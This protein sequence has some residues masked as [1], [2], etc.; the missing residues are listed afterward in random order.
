MKVLFQNPRCATATFKVSAEALWANAVAIEA[1]SRP[2]IFFMAFSAKGFFDIGPSHRR[3][4]TARP[5]ADGDSSYAQSCRIRT[6]GGTGSPAYPALR[7][8]GRAPDRGELMRVLL[9]APLTARRLP[10]SQSRYPR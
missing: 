1:T 3:I 7:A 5:T 4:I 6:I 2:S 8:T 9:A 10:R